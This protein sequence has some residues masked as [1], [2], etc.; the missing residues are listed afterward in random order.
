MIIRESDPYG[1][2]G[3]DEIRDS[4]APDAPPPPVNV[5]TDLN[6]VQ[7]I[8]TSPE[9]HP[10]KQVATAL[11]EAGGSLPLKEATQKT[12]MS[13]EQLTHLSK[14]L[15]GVFGVRGEYKGGTFYSPLFEKTKPTQ[16][17]R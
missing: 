16:P 4:P 11:H 17:R 10:L 8:A 2:F 13:V 3:V 7:K 9:S 14:L 15:R 6:I 1:N 12:G 5:D